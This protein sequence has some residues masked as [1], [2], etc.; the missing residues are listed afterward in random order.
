MMTDQQSQKQGQR[1]ISE[2]HLGHQTD[3]IGQ[4]MG[5]W[6]RKGMCSSKFLSNAIASELTERSVPG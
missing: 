6:G 4:V 5:L 3:A 2:R 1:G